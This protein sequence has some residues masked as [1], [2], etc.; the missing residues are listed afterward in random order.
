MR[1]FIASRLPRFELGLQS[2]NAAIS[3]ESSMI[4]NGRWWLMIHLASM[5]WSSSLST[6]GQSYFFHNTDESATGTSTKNISSI[7]PLFSLSFV[8]VRSRSRWI[9][10]YARFPDV[11]TANSSYH[12][13]VEIRCDR[14]AGMQPSSN[15]V[16]PPARWSSWNASRPQNDFFYPRSIYRREM[17][18]LFETWYQTR[19]MA[20]LLFGSNLIYTPDRAWYD[21]TW[22]RDRAWFD[23]CDHILWIILDVHWIEPGLVHIMRA[24]SLC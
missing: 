5:S 7:L 4:V 17:V 24:W 18:E 12:S 6:A 13:S 8:C 19:R 14:S 11:S 15:R 16:Y 9:Y 23:S 2:S 22:V 21:S 20:C 3:S 10:P 1:F